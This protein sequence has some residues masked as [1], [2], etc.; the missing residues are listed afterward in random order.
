M[1]RSRIYFARSGV[2]GCHNGGHEPIR[3]ALKKPTPRSGFVQQA[4]GGGNHYLINSSYRNLGSTNINQTLAGELKRRTTYPPLILTNDF[5]VD[6]VLLP[7][8]QRDTDMPDLGYAYEPL[9]YVV[10]GVSIT[11]ATLTLTNG[12]ALGVYGWGG[13]TLQS[14]SKFISRGLAENMN[15]ICPY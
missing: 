13:L 4:V 12:V 15:R 8:A 5:T 3:P 10:S 2:I 7:Q 11:N 9:D 1:A 14:G 6:S